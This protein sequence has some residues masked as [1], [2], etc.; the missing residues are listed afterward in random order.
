[1]ILDILGKFFLLIGSL[2]LFLGGLG[3]IRMPDTFNRLQAGTKAS[4]LGAMSVLLG[5]GLLIPGWLPKMLVFILFIVL[6]NPIS[7]HAIIR[8]TYILGN[9]E[10]I[11]TDE[12]KG[13]KK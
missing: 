3:V 8:T 5:V 1:M 4:T 11:H 10:N 2:F 13:A 9:R 12:Y 7:S 6:T